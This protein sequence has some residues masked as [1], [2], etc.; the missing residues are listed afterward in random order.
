M[1]AFFCCLELPGHTQRSALLEAVE[2]VTTGLLSPPLRRCT[3]LAAKKANIDKNPYSKNPRQKR[4]E[5]RCLMRA[6][7]TSEPGLVVF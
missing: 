2:V 3:R 4:T 7:H 6:P 1:T 5:S